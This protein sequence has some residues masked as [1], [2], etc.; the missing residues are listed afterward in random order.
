MRILL[1]DDDEALMATLAESLI[2]QRYAVDIAVNGEMAQEFLALFPYDLIVLDRLLPDAEGISLCQQFRQQGITAPILMLTARDDSADK[3]QALDAGADDY[4]VKP[5]DFEELC[6][7][8]RA[9]LRRDSPGATA[10]L[11]WGSLRL[12]PSTFEVF[13]DDHQLHITPK[14]Y[15]LLELFLRHPAQV[16]SL[17]AIIDDIW[18]FEDPPS[19]DAVRTHIKGLRQKLKAGG[20]PK[21]F[22]E[23][24][25]GVGYRLHPLEA[26]A[27]LDSANSAMD[28]RQPTLAD[29][30][31]ALAQAWQTHE[32][33]M[34]ERLSVLEATAAAMDDG[35]L[36]T[37]LQQAGR[38]QAHK[39]A[40][41][42]GCYG[43]AE[44]SQIA[45]EL[46]QLLQLTVPLDDHQTAQVFQLVQRLRQ[47]LSRQTS[48]GEV[49]APIASTAQLLI[50]GAED[51]FSQR[52]A[53]IAGEAGLRAMVAASLTQ[54]HAILQAQPPTA[55]LLWIDEPHAEAGMELLGAIAQRSAQIPVLVITD[56]RDFQ[57]R[58]RLVQLGADRLLP[59]ST[60]PHHVIEAVQQAVRV[61]G[62]AFDIVVVDD[63][64]QVL[65]LL[66]SL[67]VPWGMRVTTLADPAQLWDTL[68]RVKPQLLVLD[69]EMPTANG[70]ELCQVL[71][72]DDQWRHLPILFLTVHEDAQTLQQAF[73]V[74]A[75]DFIHKSAM[76]TELPHRILN[77]L[78]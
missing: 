46:E 8:I 10:E 3:V 34:Q 61:G 1:V 4:V 24:V 19:G 33:T 77:R 18:S 68:E 43:F 58:L 62:A 63:D 51:S 42:L 32:G 50:A 69:V 65:E 57:L 78:Q 13:Y 44:G 76:A 11:T 2:R 37:D 30:K 20:A 27:T 70:L 6:A 54:A 47:N 49:A 25:Y 59:S 55:A 40:G 75:D 39:L 31:A 56:S 45:R 22:I 21:T 14:E 52:V 29:I 53:A 66:R 9:L 35:L 48:P 67:L 73:D 72:A 16:F 28:N 26:D 17:D 74:G 12:S 71:R 7:R 38:S 36:S 41:S 64:A 60:S 23:T 15:A 5:F